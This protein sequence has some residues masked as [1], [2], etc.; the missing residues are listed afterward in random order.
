M[1]M[2]RFV[3]PMNLD[4]H[5]AKFCFENGGKLLLSY[6][7]DYFFDGEKIIAIIAIEDEKVSA[8]TTEFKNYLKD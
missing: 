8:F 2:L 3:L 5:F 7:K 6:A 1:K 4:A